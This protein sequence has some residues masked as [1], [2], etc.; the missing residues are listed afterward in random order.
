MLASALE[1][2]VCLTLPN[3]EV[4]QCNEGH[5]V[6]IDCWRRIDPRCCPECRQLLPQSNRCRAA[7]R[8]I[9][10]LDAACEHCGEA[11]KRGEMAAHLRA[12]PQR[13][14]G[15]AAAAAGCGWEGVASELGAHEMACPFAICLRMVEPLRSECKELRARV[16]A[17]EPLRAQNERLQRQ[18]A[19]LGHVSEAEEEDAATGGQHFGAM[20]TGPPP[21]NA[22]VTEM[23]LAEI[24]AALRAHMAVA[25][26]A[27]Q[28]FTRLKVLCEPPGSEQAAAE[29]GAIEAVLD[30]MREHPR[31]AGVLR[32]G[33]KALALVCYSP[34]SV[35][36][37]EAACAGSQARKQRAADARALEVVVDAMRAHPLEPGV[38]RW[39]CGALA[40][41]CEG[42]DAAALA[43]RQWAAG[44]GALEAV[45]EAFRAHRQH[46]QLQEECC[47]ALAT[48][49][50]G[51]DEAAVARKQRVVEAGAIEEVVEAMR[52]HALDTGVQHYGCWALLCVCGGGVIAAARAR[53]RRATQAGGRAAAAAALQAHP[54]DAHVQYYGKALL[55]GFPQ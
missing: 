32:W 6:C 23:E 29:A 9:A 24:V 35:A 4:H 42:I 30:A 46:S 52:V 18:V 40:N 1:C 45:V 41:V 21:S 7:E 8:A 43:R 54:G 50:G 11:T 2:P 20:A 3:G 48:V 36:G 28:A 31:A 33:C 15:C 19:A 55:Y 14:S 13:H 49:C 17:L 10:A 53:K 22:E 12:C 34:R 47:T 39:G 26:V 44:A 16:A 5:T 51:S 25:R 27:E 37:S 38:L